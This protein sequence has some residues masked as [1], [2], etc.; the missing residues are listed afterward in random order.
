VDG[1]RAL[2]VELAMDPEEDQGPHVTILPE[3]N[4]KPLTV[5]PA[6]ALK[7]ARVLEQLGTA[8]TV[9]I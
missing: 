1:Q 7:L 4:G 5:E 2:L 6:Q 9:P 3:H 8:A